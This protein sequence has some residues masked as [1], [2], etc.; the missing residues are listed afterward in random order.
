[1]IFGSFPPVATSFATGFFYDI[2]SPST[3]ELGDDKA[4]QV[5][6]EKDGKSGFL[7]LTVGRRYDRI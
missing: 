4:I 1:L 2:Y 5:F 6:T 3:A 7:Q